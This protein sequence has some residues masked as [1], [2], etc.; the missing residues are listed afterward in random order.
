V[1]VFLSKVKQKLCLIQKINFT[2]NS[3]GYK[4]EIRSAPTKMTLI[5]NI[6]DKKLLTKLQG[7]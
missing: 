7:R 1:C 6:I 3:D 4:N 2:Y 5:D